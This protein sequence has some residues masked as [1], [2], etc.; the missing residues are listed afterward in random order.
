MDDFI[1]PV[2]KYRKNRKTNKDST[3]ISPTKIMSK[4]QF[5]ALKP[6]ERAFLVAT[7][8]EALKKTSGFRSDIHNK[9]VSE[10]CV[11]EEHGSASEN[12]TS[13]PPEPRLNTRA[14]VANQFSIKPSTVRRY[15]LINNLIP[16]LKILLD[17]D[18]LKIHPAVELS[19]LNIN[20]QEQIVDI[21]NEGVDIST[22]QAKSLRTQSINNT[23]DVSSIRNIFI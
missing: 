18:I 21:L 8:Y 16:A 13:V 3:N 19:Y 2:D 4:Q 9:H 5:E 22:E 15:L 23:L 17:N 20:E 7:R 6:S 12:T 14:V 10:T 11:P 1:F